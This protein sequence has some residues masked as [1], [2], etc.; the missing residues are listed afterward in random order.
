MNPMM[1]HA[2]SG[3]PAPLL[4]PSRTR[5][6]GPPSTSTTDTAFEEDKLA[7]DALPCFEIAMNMPMHR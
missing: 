5:L 3:D 7:V 4:V 2:T 1:L 6:N